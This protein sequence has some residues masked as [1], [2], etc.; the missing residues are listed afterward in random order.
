LVPPLPRYSEVLRLRIVRPDGLVCLVPSVPSCAPCS[1]SSD[2]EPAPASLGSGQ[3][4]PSRILRRRRHDLPRFLE[5]PY[6][7]APLFDPGGPA[8]PHPIGAGRCCLPTRSR[9]S[10]T[11]GSVSRGSITQPVGSLSTLR[12]PGH[13]GATQDSLPARWLGTGRAGLSPAGS[14]IEFQ[15][16][17][18]L[19]SPRTRLSWRNERTLTVELQPPA[20][21]LGASPTVCP[22]LHRQPPAA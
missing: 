1:L 6:Q 22:I 5:N 17:R 4:L 16:G 9:S 12:R 11:T 10:A 2:T 7:R 13:P 20:T 3:R 15:F 8:R 21:D 14:L 19:A 18:H